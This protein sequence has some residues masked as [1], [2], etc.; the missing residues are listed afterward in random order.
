MMS[1]VA[2]SLREVRQARGLSL[3]ELAVAARISHR[4]LI[5]IEQGTVDPRLST[6]ERLA[7][8]LGVSVQDALRQ[9]KTPKRPRVR[10]T[11]Q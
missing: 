6:V 10:R 4:E 2:T 8:A 3:R 5:H 11:R 9:A 1:P 7:E